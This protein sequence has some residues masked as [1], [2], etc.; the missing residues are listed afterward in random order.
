MSISKGIADRYATAVF[1]IAVENDHLEELEENIQDLSHILEISDD[2]HDVI[3]SPVIRRI[4]QRAVMAKVAE[5]L[6]LSQ[7]MKNLL[8]LMAE[9]RRL[10]VLPVLCQ[11]IQEKIATFRGELTAEIKCAKELTKEQI[12]KLSNILTAKLGKD[13]LMKV[14]VEKSLIG[15]LVVKI[16]SIMIDTSIAA[17]LDSLQNAMKEVD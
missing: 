3:A 5:S 6:N 4:E 2:L 14:T 11:T 15:G 1:E 13:I 8:F 16:G 12:D 9:K 7:T 17:K 10:F